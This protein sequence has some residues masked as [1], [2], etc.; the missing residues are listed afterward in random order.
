VTPHRAAEVTAP[1]PTAEPYDPATWLPPQELDVL[2]GMADGLTTP[3]IAARLE[4][5][6]GTVRGW[7]QQLY[8]RLGVSTGPHA[9]AVAYQRG[10]LAVDPGVTAAAALLRK[11]AELGFRLAVVPWPADGGEVR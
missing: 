8:R 6:H 2:R 3:D 10:I 1:A 5:S 4:V 7:Q 9:V 11:A